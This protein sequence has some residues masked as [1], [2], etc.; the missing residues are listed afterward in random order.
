MSWTDHDADGE[1]VG[2]VLRWDLPDGKKN[3]RP[4][5]RHADGWRLSGMPD[6]RPLYRLPE[7]A[8][9][10][11]VF[12]CEEEK[13]ADAARSIGLTATTSAH[14]S[15]SAKQTDWGPLAGKAVVILAD[16]DAPGRQYAAT[17]ADILRG[18]EDYRAIEKC[19]A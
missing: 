14:G 4:V 15:S 7:L 3:I 17:V 11:R 5:S 8:N 6:T 18:T 12:V 19:A 2:I 1:P 13:A 9:A 16:H 10:D